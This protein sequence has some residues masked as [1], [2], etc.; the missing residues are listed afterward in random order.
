VAVGGKIFGGHGPSSFARPQRLSETTIEPIKNW[1][2]GKIWGPVPA[3][4]PSLKPPLGYFFVEL[5]D[6]VCGSL[7]RL[8]RN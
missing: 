2:L 3:P 7:R 6:L 1:G 8:L 5:L 4:G